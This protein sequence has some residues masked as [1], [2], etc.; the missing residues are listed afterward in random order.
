MCLCRCITVCNE[1][2]D[3]APEKLPAHAPPVQDPEERIKALLDDELI[4][5]VMFGLEP[6]SAD[7]W[8][9]EVEESIAAYLEH[10]K[11]GM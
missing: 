11:V 2:S 10:D 3:I 1:G 6:S 4:L 7:R 9:E 8:C 5:G